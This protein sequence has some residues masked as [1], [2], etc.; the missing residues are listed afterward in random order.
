M[1]PAAWGSALAAIKVA[2][3]ANGFNFKLLRVWFPAFAGTTLESGRL[4]QP[5]VYMMASG[6]KGTQYLGIT[7]NLPTRIWQHKEAFVESFTKRH[8][9]KT[10]VWYE[11]HETYGVCHHSRKGHEELEPGVETTPH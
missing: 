9:V 3:Y 4:K 5:C 2:A 8:G 7:S 10:L 6:Q 1:P 11:L